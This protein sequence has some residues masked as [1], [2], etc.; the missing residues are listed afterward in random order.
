ME[1]SFFGITDYQLYLFNEGTNYHSYKMLGAHL[2]KINGV[3][4][5]RFAVWAP[6][7]RRVSV[8]GDFNCWDG[9]VHI[10]N[11]LGD[12]GVWTLFIP[13]V[14]EF[15]LYKYEIENYYGQ[16][17]LKADPY[18]FYSEV[19]PGTASIVYDLN[20]YE[21]RD[22]EWLQERTNTPIYD[23]PLLIYEVHL[24]SW[25]RKEG[26]RFLSYRELAAELIPY[27]KDMGYTHI[28]L[29]PV[30][31]HPYDGSWGYQTTGY[32]SVTSRY[33][34]PEDFMFFIDECH[35]AGIGVIL[36]WVP[37]HF[38]KDEHG[39]R[40][41]DGTALYEHEDPRRGEHPHWGTL[42]FN[43][44]RN[45]VRS[46]LI[47]NAIFWFDV[48]HVDGLRVD[49]VASMLY[50]DYGKSWG[51]WLPNRY[52]GKEN[53]EAI[54]FM[55][56]MNEVVFQYF[57]NVLMIAEESTAWPMVTRPVYLGG[58][59]FNY[60]WN[61]GWMNDMLRYMSLDPVYRKWHHENLTFSMM[62]A[63]SENFILPLSH[64]EVV[65]GKR[66]L[67]DKMPGDYWQKFANLRLLYAYMMAHPGKKLLFMGGEFGQF[68][69]WNF[70]A[71]L[72]W[73]LLEYEMHRKLHYY[74]K[75]LN[76]F[77]LD[78]RALW[79]CDHGWEGFCW[80]DHRDYS[81]S[82]IAFLRK[83]KGQDECLI[84]VCNFTPVVRYGYR[85]GVPWPGGYE[86][87]FNSDDPV[88]GGSGQGNIGIIVAEGIPWHGFEQSI[89]ITVPPLAAVFLKRNKRR[90]GDC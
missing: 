76:H 86:E 8:V 60:K 20:K 14:K 41:F 67:L 87:V 71:G 38:P 17:V 2:I 74:V 64:D 79:E 15:D 58:L 66:S 56:R 39:L 72:D 52:G 45:E 10:M 47:S 82:I 46:F 51:E 9:R 34:T 42:I 27:V 23:K 1:T 84:V 25:R 40:R 13:G 62:Y 30:A 33:G 53:L 80:I 35:L 78:N 24:G 88:Y 4:G 36:D 61:M 77:Y 16:V 65:H 81:Q 48:Y 3:E 28:E 19:R 63:F 73:H 75:M 18:A 89:S 55:R 11:R 5:T 21:W 22:D 7:A 32:Y 6:N 69:E 29:L 54:E 83:S 26:N 44:G 59:G 68:A 12:S 37:A 43:Y 50:L 85:I 90:L 70:D 31:E 57:P 49:A